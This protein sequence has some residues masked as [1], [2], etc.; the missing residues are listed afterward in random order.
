ME[1]INGIGL[2]ALSVAMFWRGPDLVCWCVDIME[3]CEFRTGGLGFFVMLL[4]GL[5]WAASGMLL[6]FYGISAF[7]SA[8]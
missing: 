5:I 6:M 4:L 2:M 1:I 8:S 7:G 3:Q